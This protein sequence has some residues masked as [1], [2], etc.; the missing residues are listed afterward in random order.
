MPKNHPPNTGNV[1]QL[2][3][4][5]VPDEQAGELGKKLSMEGFRFTLISASNGFLP[6]GITCLMLGIFSGDNGPLMRLVEKICKTKLRYIP[7]TSDFSL[8]DGMSMT[9]IEA[10]IGSTLIYVI[11]VEIFETF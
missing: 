4:I 11:P 8:G 5:A 3:L 10:E 2:V 7:A 9:M 6:T 1:D